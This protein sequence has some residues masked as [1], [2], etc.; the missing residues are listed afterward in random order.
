M[1]FYRY[2]NVVQIK[3]TAIK[4]LESIVKNVFMLDSIQFFKLL[5]RCGAIISGSITEQ[6]IYGPLINKDSDIDIYVPV[7][8]VDISRYLIDFIFDA[9]YSRVEETQP[10]MADDTHYL[11]QN[12]GYRCNH[13]IEGVVI[14]K[15]KTTNKKIQIISVANTDGMTTYEFGQFVVSSFDF[16]FLKNFYDGTTLYTFM[17]ELS[18]NEFTQLPEVK[19]FPS[20]ILVF[21]YNGHPH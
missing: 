15:H 14:L 3:K 11:P 6:I 12:L 9:D 8:N 17:M 20:S 1:D 18:K 13:S 10:V 2:Y 19:T 5:E 21:C 16:T 7:S 4:N